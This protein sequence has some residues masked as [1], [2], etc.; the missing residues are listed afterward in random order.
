MLIRGELSITHAYCTAAQGRFD[1]ACTRTHVHR[2]KGAGAMMPRCGWWRGGLPVLRRRRRWTAPLQVPFGQVSGRRQR[3]GFCSFQLWRRQAWWLLTEAGKRQQGQPILCKLRPVSLCLSS[4]ISIAGSIS[5]F[6]PCSPEL[7]GSGT[8]VLTSKREP[9][10]VCV[11]AGRGRP[12]GWEGGRKWGRAVW[13][14]CD[15]D[16]R[17]RLGLNATPCNLMN[18]A[19]FCCSETSSTSDLA[20]CA[21]SPATE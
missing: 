19:R 7:S 11:R 4:P 18:P 17:S 5:L 13:L 9:L 3:R 14:A 6:C 2:G 8:A 16:Y 1:Y 20:P 21:L 12:G 10:S 15:D